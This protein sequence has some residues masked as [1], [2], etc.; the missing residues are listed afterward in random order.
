[1]DIRPPPTNCWAKFYQRLPHGIARKYRVQVQKALGISPTVFN[2]KIN[3]SG[4]RLTI[5]EKRAVARI[6]CG[7]FLKSQFR[8]CYS[9]YGN[10]INITLLD[11]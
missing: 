3:G 6:I 4:K 9:H 10:H 5:T 1:M 11:E 8:N 2:K 7:L